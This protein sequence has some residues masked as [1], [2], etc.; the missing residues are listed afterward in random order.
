MPRAVS[1]VFISELDWLSAVV[2]TERVL[3]DRR[4]ESS[5]KAPYLSFRVCN[6]L[7][8]VGLGDGMRVIEM[9]RGLALVSCTAG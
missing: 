8:R 9:G 5:V 2:E 6:E 1:V 3:A 4:C 7:V